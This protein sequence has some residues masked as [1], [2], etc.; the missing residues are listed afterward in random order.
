ML[1]ARQLV[2]A[3]VQ[4]RQRVD[5]PGFL[6]EILVVIAALRRNGWIQY[7]AARDLGLTSRQMGYRVRKFGLEG[8]IAQERARDRSL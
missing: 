8:L 5:D 2:R 6:R 1:D 7:K 4:D 3:F